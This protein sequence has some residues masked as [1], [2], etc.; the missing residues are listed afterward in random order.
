MGDRVLY[1]V[2][3][4]KAGEIGPVVYSHWG[5]KAAPEVV[6]ALRLRM[7]DRLSDVS[8][9]SARLVQLICSHDGNR[10]AGVWNAPAELTEAESHA[11]GGCVVINC[12]DWS[13]RAFG[14]YLKA[15][16]FKA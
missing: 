3:S 12:D 14:G 13:V 5:A 11:D 8:Y 2:V 7:G 4:R 16:Q 1:Q 6:S 15:E 9:T 10:G